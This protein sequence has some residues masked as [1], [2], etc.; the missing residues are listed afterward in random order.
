MSSLGAIASCHRLTALYGNVVFP[1]PHYQKG[2]RLQSCL[3]LLVLR[4]IVIVIVSIEN[5]NLPRH[6]PTTLQMQS[7]TDQCAKVIDFQKP[8]RRRLR[9]VDAV[10]L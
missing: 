4:R 6:Q 3:Y 10:Q 1:T 8:E 2:N 5:V 9:L 7:L